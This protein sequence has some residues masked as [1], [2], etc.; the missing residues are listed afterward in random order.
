MFL[1]PVRLLMKML[2]V[3]MPLILIMSMLVLLIRYPY[4]TLGYLIGFLIAPTLLRKT[5]IYHVDVS[6]SIGVFVLKDQEMKQLE[7]IYQNELDK[8]TEKRR[9]KEQRF[10]RKIQRLQQETKQLDKTYTE[11]LDGKPDRI[12]YIQPRS[13]LQ[14]LKNRLFYQGR[15]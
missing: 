4:V 12:V 1:F 7:T 13:F 5:G 2:W 9:S 14:L 3:L 8:S 6:N 10:Q 11:L 15:G